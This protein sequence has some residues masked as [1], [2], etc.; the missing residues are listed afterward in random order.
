MLVISSNFRP[1]S[2]S[3]FTT[4][5]LR[6]TVRLE[7]KNLEIQDQNIFQQHTYERMGLPFTTLL[8]L[9]RAVILRFE[10]GTTHD[11]NLLYQIRDSPNL[12]SKS[13]PSPS[14][15]T[16]DGQSVR[17][18]WCRAP[19]GAHDQILV[20]AW[21][22]LSCLGEGALFDERVGLSFVRVCRK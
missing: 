11:H 15:F 7:D 17:L 6:Q 18:S 1:S 10:S 19:S 9:E 20:T 22:F 13:S 4:G 2:Q 12:E 14:H 8:P 3:H 5:S 16:T 21:Q